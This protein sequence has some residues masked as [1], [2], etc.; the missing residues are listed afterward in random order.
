MRAELVQAIAPLTVCGWLGQ[1]CFFTRFLLQW[2][3]SERAPA[4]AGGGIAD[5]NDHLSSVG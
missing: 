5:Q 1:A 3:A 4:S 2:A